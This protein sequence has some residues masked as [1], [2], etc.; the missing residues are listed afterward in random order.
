MSAGI[1]DL[2][3]KLLVLKHGRSSVVKT[4]ARVCDVSESDLETQLA[5]AAKTKESKDRSV[6]PTGAELLARIEVSE[7]I[8]ELLIELVHEYECKRFLGELRLVEKFY[9]D[10]GIRPAPKARAD[11]LP[12]V[13]TVLAKLPLTELRELL[14]TVR[15]GGSDTAFAQLAGAI[16][17]R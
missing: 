16:I 17:G 10:H 15:E 1:I 12:K 3:V 9:F 11:A 14:A 2:E 4:L 8:R 7:E 13:I 6:K 5:A